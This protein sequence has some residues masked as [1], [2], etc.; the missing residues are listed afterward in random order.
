MIKPNF[1]IGGAARS[2]STSLYSFLKEHPE[3]CMSKI[4]EPQFFAENYERG[5]EWYL[6]LFNQTGKNSST[7]FNFISKLYNVC[8]GNEKAIGEASTRYLHHKKAPKRIKSFNPNMKLIF[9]LRNPIYRAF[10]NYKREIETR[11]I[12]DDFED[13]IKNKEHPRWDEYIA[14]GNYYTHIKRYLKYFNKEQIHIIIFEHYITNFKEENRKIL[15]F[16]GLDKKYSFDYEKI[17]KNKSI[18]PI[19]TKVQRLIH[20]YFYINPFKKYEKQV[21]KYPFNIFLNKLNHCIV[22]NDFPDFKEDEKKILYDYYKNEINRL[23]GLIK[24]DL[25]VWELE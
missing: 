4:K 1:L 9:I 16:L 18:P 11:G 10:S 19:S 17:K 24:K 14:R 21:F 15:N 25:G 23:E 2:G 7:F 13:I 22:I 6:N 8:E 20:K 3:V 12:N 5:V